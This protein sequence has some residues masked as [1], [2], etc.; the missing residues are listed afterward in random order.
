MTPSQGLPVQFGKNRFGDEFFLCMDQSKLTNSSEAKRTKGGELRGT[1]SES[2][3]IQCGTLRVGL[4][5]FLKVRRQRVT[6]LSHK[7]QSPER[8]F[9]QEQRGQIGVGSKQFVGGQIDPMARSQV[10]A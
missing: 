6:N 5:R 1:T 7:I 10:A 3:E 9:I 8:E 4:K 2:R